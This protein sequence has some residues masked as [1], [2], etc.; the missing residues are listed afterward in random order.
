M[1]VSWPVDNQDLVKSAMDRV[2][3]DSSTVLCR[4][5]PDSRWPSSDYRQP[6]YKPVSI[7]LGETSLASSWP[8]RPCQWTAAGDSTSTRLVYKRDAV[9]WADFTS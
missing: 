6:D 3:G 2:I 8:T 4:I 5:G 9:Y 1:V 7:V